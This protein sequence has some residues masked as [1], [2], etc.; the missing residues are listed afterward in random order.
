VPLDPINSL[1]EPDRLALA[2]QNVRTADQ[3]TDRVSQ[4]PQFPD[5]FGPAAAR[6]RDFVA[7]YRYLARQRSEDFLRRSLPFTEGRIRNHRFDIMVLLAI[8]FIAFAVWR[9]RHTTSPPKASQAVLKS[10]LPPFHLITTPDLQVSCKSGMAPAQK[11]LDDLVGRYSLEYLKPCVPIDPKKLSSGPRLSTELHG[12][13]IVRLK[14]QPTSVFA[15]MYPPF[16][17]VLMVAP[18]ERG[19]T[20]LLLNDL[21]VLDL[22]R[23]AEGMS[24]VVAISSADDPTLASFVARSD[25]WLVAALP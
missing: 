14:L 1:P 4:D 2:V 21:F 24:A 3:L 10:G 9:D 17:A 15:G 20:S 5:Q 13:T 23:D 18:R 25:L 19:T 22:Q 12:R 6:I 16:K 11:S 7:R 8:V